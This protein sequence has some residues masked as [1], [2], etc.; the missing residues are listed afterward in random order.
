MTAFAAAAILI[1]TL[2]GLRFKVLILAPAMALGSP[3][4]LAIGLVY[5]DSVWLVLFA[6]V[7]AAAA[8]QVGYFTGA[9]IRVV[10]IATCVRKGLFGA[11][12]VAQRTIR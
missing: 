3:V 5:N 7:L 2:L 9:I 10:V 11:T 6:M 12:V 1:G 8:L 4:T